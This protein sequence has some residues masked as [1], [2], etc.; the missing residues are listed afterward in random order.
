MGRKNM[1]FYYEVYHELNPKG[2]VILAFDTR[3]TPMGVRDRACREGHFQ[4]RFYP[5]LKVRKTRNLRTP[6]L[7]SFSEVLPNG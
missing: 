3:Q 6:P 2:R 5:E 7:E 1:T 4:W